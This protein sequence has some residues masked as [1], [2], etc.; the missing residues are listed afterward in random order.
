MRKLL[1]VALLLVALP[2]AAHPDSTRYLE[3]VRDVVRRHLGELRRCYEIVLAKR[4]DARASFTLKFTIAKDGSVSDATVDN[5]RLADAE[6]L[7]CALKRARRWT[8][9]RPADAPV[10][11]TYPLNVDVAGD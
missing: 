4:P 9:P 2:A 3:A 1:R 6:I 10:V 5:G 11:V 7:A 8:F